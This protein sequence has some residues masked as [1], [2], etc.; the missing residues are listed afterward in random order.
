MHCASCAINVEKELNKLSGVK[1]AV[2]NYANEEATVEFD[3]KKVSEKKFT[4]AAKR[5]GD[6]EVVSSEPM[7]GMDHAEHTAMLKEA[8]IKALRN[9][10][11]FGAVISVI[12][13]VLTM[14]PILPRE[15]SFPL[16]L[17]LTTPVLF[18]AG[19]QFYKSALVSARRFRANMDTLIAVGTGAAF[20]YSLVATLFP[21]FFLSAGQE[22]AVYYDTAA[23][24]VT[25][26]LLGKF[27]EARAKGQAGKAIQELAKLQA[28]TARVIRSG[29]EIE[30]PIEEVKVGDQI[31]VRP[32]EKIPVDG[33][34]IEGASAIDESMITGESIPV[35]KKAGDEVIGSTINKSGSFIFEAKHVGTETALSQ[36]IKLVREAQGSKAPIQRLADVISGYFVP[37]VMSIALA[38]F[39]IWILLVGQSLAFSLIIAVT[40]LIIACPCALGLATPTAIM[41]GTGR[42]ASLG[43]LI[44]NAEALEK[45]HKLKT[46]VLDKTGTITKGEP[47]VTDVVG[48]N[49]MLTLAASVES[50][51][52]HPL[53]VAIVQ[54]ATSKKL[55]LQKPTQFKV[56]EGYGL[57]AM[58][59]SK[60]VLVGK[61][62]WF[63]KQKIEL[64]A[65]T[66]DIERLQKE[67]KT[68]SVVA[69]DG[70]ANGLIALADT[71]KESSAEAIALLKK[72]GITSI[73]ITGDNQQTAEA[74]AKQ[75][76][77]DQVLAEVLPKDKAKEV[78]KLQQS[79]EAIGMVGDGINDAPALAQSDLGFAIGS[80]T[81]V[82]IE[83]ADIVLVKNDL[84]DVARAINLSK[85][86]MGTIKGNLFWAFAYNTAGIPIAAG[87]LFPF[88]ILLSPIFASAAMAFSSIFVV[89]NSLR[90][91]SKKI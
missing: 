50:L 15:I 18:W 35:D 41:V 85:K 10:F 16:M 37:I 86:T 54:Y 1:S 11:V 29:K 7:A 72:M 40:V 38:A 55:K 52:E 70:V 66:Q 27:L 47:E 6:Y 39:L 64:E 83:S 4:E 46:I 23:I 71:V 87:V 69:V 59:G 34:I 61:P 36:I 3:E 19:G 73:M 62:G 5:V 17:V 84:R 82:A 42:G 26:I 91:K 76:G 88:G 24:I 79:T 80:G 57:E 43:I 68:V 67:G 20:L 53:G 30:V 49:D 48:T 22:V 78:K 51:S 12:V 81:D 77:I 21:Q 13:L 56:A 75:V 90:L 89:L 33:V 8:E 58:A 63:S 65:L 45:A 28:K 60:K 44:K 14:V 9:K 31:V 2:V 74:I 25:L 32:G